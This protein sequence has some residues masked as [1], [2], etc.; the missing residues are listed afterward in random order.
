MT[1]VDNIRSKH[2][3]ASLCGI[4]TLNARVVEVHDF[5]PDVKVGQFI[6][7]VI[8]RITLLIYCQR[9]K[10]LVR[11]EANLCTYLSS[12]TSHT[13]LRLLSFMKYKCHFLDQHQILCNISKAQP[14]T[15]SYRHPSIGL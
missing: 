15:F 6:P 9:M 2:G 1:R 14:N 11:T 13:Y 10:S 5:M 3:I 7:I 12:L 8:D 4:R